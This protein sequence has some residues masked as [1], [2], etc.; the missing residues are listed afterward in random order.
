MT[1]SERLCIFDLLISSRRR[2]I[3]FG[4]KR[5]ALEI[6]SLIKKANAPRNVVFPT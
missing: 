5:M 4:M 3:T 6:G 2:T 1:A